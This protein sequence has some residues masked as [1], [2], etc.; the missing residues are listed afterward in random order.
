M[1]I[2]KIGNINNIIDPKGIKSVSK[3]R[4]TDKIDSLQISSEGKEAAELSK[5]A[6]IVKEVPDIRI[7]KVNAI[8]EQI[9]NG[10][11]DKFTD[12]KILE[13]VADKI[14]ENLLRR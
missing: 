7:D 11:Y 14:A 3:N 1:V 5:Y 12:D 9:Q 6:Q 13:M 4:K 10:T 2:D 8:K